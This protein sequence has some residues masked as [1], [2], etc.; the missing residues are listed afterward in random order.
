MKT[1]KDHEFI[2]TNLHI[3]E[4]LFSSITQY[5]RIVTEKMSYGV[6]PELEFCQESETED[7]ALGSWGSWWDNDPLDQHMI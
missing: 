1:H 4:F 7:R 3:C 5:P 6:F 2:V